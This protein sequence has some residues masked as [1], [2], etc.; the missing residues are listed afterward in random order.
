MAVIVGMIVSMFMLVAF[1]FGF[2]L[3]AAADGT[4]AGF[5]CLN[6]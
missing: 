6:L 2:T 4:H 5:S 1:D 3:A